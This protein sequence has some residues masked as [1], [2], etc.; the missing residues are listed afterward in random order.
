M[1]PF[2]V[3]DL[4][5]CTG[6]HVNEAGPVTSPEWSPSAPWHSA[7]FI[8]HSR[9]LVFL[10]KPLTFLLLFLLL[11]NDL[12][13]YLIEKKAKIKVMRADINFNPLINPLASVYIQM[14]WFLSCYSVLHLNTN[15]NIFLQFQ[16][17]SPQP[18]TIPFLRL[19]QC[20]YNTCSGASPI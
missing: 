10:Q 13:S 17:F 19:Q 5:D 6:L 1:E 11:F 16:Q 4:C 18:P 7:T 9:K 14:F 8:S 2:W 3:Q 20:S 15:P 12:G